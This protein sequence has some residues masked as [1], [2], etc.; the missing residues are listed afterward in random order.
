V[1]SFIDSFVSLM[2][3]ELIINSDSYIDAQQPSIRPT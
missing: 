2:H 1:Y 3:R